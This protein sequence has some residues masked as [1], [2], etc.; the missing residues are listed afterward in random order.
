MRKDAN[1]G[2]YS[3]SG[4]FMRWIPVEQAVDLVMIQKKALE[5]FDGNGKSIGIRL[6]PDAAID[7]S[8]SE[9]PANISFEEMQLNAGVCDED[10]PDS[11]IRAVQDKVFWYNKI[12]DSKSPL[13]SVGARW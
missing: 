5:H 10:E 6:L 1:V 2:L 7:Y 9:S 11:H 12:G 4:R 8:G 3:D 13:P